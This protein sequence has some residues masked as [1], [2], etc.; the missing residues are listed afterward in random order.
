VSALAGWGL[1]RVT[2][3]SLVNNKK[4]IALSSYI[5]Y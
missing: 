4:F 1:S 5:E 3:A 2:H